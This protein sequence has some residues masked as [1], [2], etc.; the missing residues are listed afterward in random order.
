MEAVPMRTALAMVVAPLV[1]MVGCSP[2]SDAAASDANVGAAPPVGDVGVVRAAIDSA[3]A[4][5]T[6]AIQAGDTAA[7]FAPFAN[8]AIVMW[9]NEK[10][11]HGTDQIRREMLRALSGVT[12]KASRPHTEDVVVSGDLAVE[13]G[14]YEWVVAPPGGKDV[15]ERGKYLTVWQRQPDGA[16][17]VLRDISNSNPPEQQK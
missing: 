3:H 17:K 1:A 13:T 7:V 6:R 8:D 9:Q 11:W 16:W 12:L 5:T 4:R 14:T 2:S 15:T 10:A